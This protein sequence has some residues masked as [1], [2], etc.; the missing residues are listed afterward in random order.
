MLISNVDFSKFKDNDFKLFKNEMAGE[1]TD[2]GNV[3]IPSMD[4]ATAF[5]KFLEFC[6]EGGSE[7]PMSP[8]THSLYR[9]AWLPCTKKATVGQ[10]S[11]FATKLAKK[12]DRC[13]N[14]VANN[15]DNDNISVNDNNDNISVCSVE[16]DMGDAGGAPKKKRMYWK[17]K[18]QQILWS[19]TNPEVGKHDF[20]NDLVLQHEPGFFQ[21]L[22]A[23][24]I[25]KTHSIWQIGG[26]GTID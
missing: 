2:Q 13:V 17:L 23:H 5:Y 7:G 1:V 11:A 20:V 16:M 24:N 25:L 18:S 9:Y 26:H 14:D 21:A 4:K 3:R 12:I 10:F 6:S 8:F 22:E 19:I 15:D